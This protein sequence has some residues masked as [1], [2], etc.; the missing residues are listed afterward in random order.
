MED[1]LKKRTLIKSKI[2]RFETFLINQANQKPDELKVRLDNVVNLLPEYESIQFKIE[3]LDSTQESDREVFEDRFYEL[4]TEARKILNSFNPQLDTPRISTPISSND[5]ST[6]NKLNVKLPKITLPE[7]NGHYEKWLPF[8][9]AFNA[10]IHENDDLNKTQKFYYLRSCLKGEASYV[11]DSLE[12]SDNNYTVAI[13]LLKNRF[14]NKRIIVQAHIRELYEYSPVQRESHVHLRKLIDHYQK[15]I[16]SLKTLG[17]PTEYWDTLLIHLIS[18]KIDTKTKRAW[19]SSIKTNAI[20]DLKQLFDFLSSQCMILESVERKDNKSN[21][22]SCLVINKPKC[23]LCDENHALYQCKTFLDLTPK[24][25]LEKVKNFKLCINCLKPGHIHGNCKLGNCKKCDNAHNTL[26]HFEKSDCSTARSSNPATTSM[27]SAHTMNNN[28][29]YVL[30][31]TALLWVKNAMGNLIRCRALVDSCSQSNFITTE[32]ASKLNLQKTKVLASINGVNQSNFNA[33]TRT[34]TDIYSLN[35]NF[36]KK[37]SF[38]IIDKITDKLPQQKIDKERLQ[39]PEKLQLADP[40][41]HK[42][43]SVDILLGASV[44]FELLSIGQIKLNGNEGPILQKTKLGWIIAGNIPFSLNCNSCFLI[45]RKTIN[46]NTP[47]L[48]SLER[49]WEIEESPKI[50]HLS[51]ED[52]EVETHFRNTYQRETDGRFQVSLP[53][54]DN[55]QI[56][57]ESYD[58]AKRRLISLETKF[59]K[60]SELKKEYVK[61]MSDYESLGHMSE[62]GADELG[63]SDASNEVVNYVPHHCVLKMSSTTT[64]LRVLVFEASAKK[65][66]TRSIDHDFYM[67]DLLTGANTEQKVL[68]LKQEISGI[69]SQGKFELRKFNS[70]SHKVNNHTELKDLNLI[71]A[72]NLMYANLEDL[73]KDPDISNYFRDKGVIWHFIPARSPHFG[74]IWEAT[75]RR[76]KY[77]LIRTIGNERLT[78]ETFSTVLIQIESILNSRP[79]L[80]LSSDPQDLELLTPGHFLIGAALLAV[81]EVDVSEIPANRLA[82]YKQLQKLHQSFWKRW[83]LKYLHTLQQR[84]KWRFYREDLVKIGSM[85]LLKDDNL[86]PM[87]WKTGR[88]EELHPGPDGKAGVMLRLSFIDVVSERSKG[89]TCRVV[90]REKGSVRYEQ[91]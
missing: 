41:F 35:K 80:P 48:K 36:N 76:V 18:N 75:V 43:N 1:L 58:I 7:F 38:L 82:N 60:K 49:C 6:S 29:E 78:Y 34:Q 3:S 15:H 71:E 67:D 55:P 45:T 24:Q 70:N 20:P 79:L 25:R 33:T 22:V 86:P 30:L 12:A 39:I 17:Q 56:L 44:F 32:L 26:L 16:R 23:R 54:K 21:T 13:E 65:S 5:N 8:I 52:L 62:V 28:N 87:Q 63:K 19:E 74:E 14:E 61:F 53:L 73:A 4:I 85:V 37:L 88:I 9:D 69:L 50:N 90:T 27:V 91:R 57:G 31:S 51:P 66:A 10:L 81:P 83:S 84:T 11:I 2:T 77:H 72:K 46:E 47:L 89:H 42:P 59:A 64:K 68:Q 40:D